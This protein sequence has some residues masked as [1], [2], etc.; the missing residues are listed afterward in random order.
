M[1]TFRTDAARSRSAARTPTPHSIECQHVSESDLLHINSMRSNRVPSLLRTHRGTAL[2]RVPSGGRRVRSAVGGVEPESDSPI[3]GKPLPCSD[4]IAADPSAPEPG[5]WVWS[6]LRSGTSASRN[7]SRLVAREARRGA[8][9]AALSPGH[10]RR[11]RVAP[12]PR[13]PR[14]SH[15]RSDSAARAVPTRVFAVRNGLPISKDP[16]AAEVAGSFPLGCRKTN[17]RTRN[18]R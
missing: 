11:T 13:S 5:E 10:R 12:R 17:V 18:A 1:A 14:S 6:A 15:F 9:S 4:A 2:G 7:P 3:Q 16:R 8:Q